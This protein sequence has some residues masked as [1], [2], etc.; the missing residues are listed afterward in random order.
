M[1]YQGD[2]PNTFYGTEHR[3]TGDDCGTS[4]PS[5]GAIT[6][7]KKLAGDWHTFAVKWTPTDVT[8]YVDNVQQGSPQ[9]LFDSGAQQMIIALTM[10]GC[11]WD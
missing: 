6:Q 4:D 3:N 9:A 8:W 10:Q 1:E 5:R 7:P 11:G 2:E